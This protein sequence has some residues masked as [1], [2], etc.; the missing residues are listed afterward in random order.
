MG[1]TPVIIHVLRAMI[2]LLVILMILVGMA[3]FLVQHESKKNIL[4]ADLYK[5]VAR[6]L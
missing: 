5:I 6:R 4:A 3:I 2:A 1:I